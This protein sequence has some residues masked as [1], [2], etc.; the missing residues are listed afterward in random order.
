ME[1]YLYRPDNGQWENEPVNIGKKYDMGSIQI[2]L[3]KPKK[4]LKTMF[5]RFMLHRLQ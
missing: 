1:L 2:V 4:V 5:L 3:N